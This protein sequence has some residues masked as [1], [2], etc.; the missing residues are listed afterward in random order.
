[1]V[2]IRKIA[3]YDRDTEYALRLAEYI[4]EYR[5]RDY[6]VLAFSDME[7]LE[8]FIISEGADIVLADE[9]SIINLRDKVDAW[10]INKAIALT[11]E[12]SSDYE[13]NIFKYQAAED[14]VSLV[15]KLVEYAAGTGKEENG[16]RIELS[17]RDEMEQIMLVSAAF[18]LDVCNIT[19]GIN[20]YHNNKYL[21][22]DCSILSGLFDVRDN[23]LSR[24]IYLLERDMA[25]NELFEECICWKNDVAYIAG[26]NDY[27]DIMELS[28]EGIERFVQ[29]AKNA[30][31]KGIIFVC[32]INSAIGLSKLNDKKSII[33]LEGGGK[34]VRDYTYK[35]IKKM[36]CIKDDKIRLIN[37]DN[38]REKYLNQVVDFEGLDYEKGGLYKLINELCRK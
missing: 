8:E 13:D 16:E 24:A 9:K 28:R 21:I 17:Q 32:D 3:I 37:T 22:V 15:E 33:V 23:K 14:I 2:I 19:L 35:I 10:S 12:K 31:Y 26:I 6:K 11:E 7:K 20:Q 5:T 36:G 29:A 25:N 4:S 27:S 38:I 34:K 1:M 30:G 18:P